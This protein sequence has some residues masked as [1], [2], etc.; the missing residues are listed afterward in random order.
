MDPL[1]FHGDGKKE[2]EEKLFKG[3]AFSCKS[4]VFLR[5][6]SAFTSKTFVKEVIQGGRKTVS[7]FRF[8]K[9]RSTFV[10]ECKSL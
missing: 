7:M 5:E 3:F 10:R 6:T 1:T 4:I 8:L 9:E 2:M